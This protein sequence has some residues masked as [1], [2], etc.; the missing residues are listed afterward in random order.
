[1]LLAADVGNTLITLG[2]HDGTAWRGR[3]RVR[4][5]PDKTADEYGILIEGMLARAGLGGVE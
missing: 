3:W 2:V 5:V 4:T 1:M